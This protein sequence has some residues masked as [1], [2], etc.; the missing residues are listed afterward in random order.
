MNKLNDTQHYTLA[1]T[2]EALIDEYAKRNLN[3]E[4]AI[5]EG[6]RVIHDPKERKIMEY[7]ISSANRRRFMMYVIRSTLENSDITVSELTKSLGI[8]RNSV[9]TMIKQCSEAGWINI[10]RCSKNHKYLTACDNLLNC[11][12]NYS[13]WLYKEVQET[14]CRE[15]G[16]N[17]N[18]V[19]LMM[20]DMSA[21]V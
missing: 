21:L 14:G 11:Y 13:K 19:N 15:A 12:R 6:A 18:R 4:I 8:T 20:D 7:S 10:S 5:S 3:V 2:K 17:L 1:E 9:E 16:I